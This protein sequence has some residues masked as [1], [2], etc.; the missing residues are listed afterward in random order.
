MTFEQTRAWVRGQ[1]AGGEEIE[2]VERLRGG[3]SSDMRR[4]T[5]RGPG[6]RR[7][8]VLRSFSKPFYLEHAPAML[9]REAGILRLLG[10]TEVPAAELVALDPTGEHCEHTS[11][12]MTL[13]PGV[14]AG[15]SFAAHYTAAGG[16]L[17]PDPADHRYWRLLD[18][19]A[20]AP[21]AEKVAVPWREVGRTDLTPELLTDRLETYPA[22]LLD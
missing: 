3:W 18:A 19:L 22:A 14:P 9:G 7:V 1:L 10:P 13:L 15:L 2:T 21:D 8:L 16:A 20:Y 12:L 17:A 5:V 6:G 11:L 4:I